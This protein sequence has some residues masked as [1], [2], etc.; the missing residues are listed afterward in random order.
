MKRKWKSRSGWET[1]R[2]VGVRAWCYF[3][4]RRDSIPAARYLVFSRSPSS[5]L[6]RLPIA[7][8]PPKL[9]KTRLSPRRCRQPKSTQSTPHCVCMHPVS[10]WRRPA[11]ARNCEGKTQIGS[12]FNGRDLLANNT[13]HT[14]THRVGAV[15]KGNQKSNDSAIGPATHTIEVIP[16][17]DRRPGNDHNCNEMTVH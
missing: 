1:E 15:R 6:F 13:T 16:Q 17:S 3:R 8:V 9:K 4:S 10:K 14:H 12:L 7:R 5:F 2:V 11:P